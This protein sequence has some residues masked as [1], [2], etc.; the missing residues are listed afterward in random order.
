[1][2]WGCDTWPRSDL[3]RFSELLR[4]TG[5][6]DTARCGICRVLDMLEVSSAG[7][8]IRL[9]AVLANKAC[10]IVG[11]SACRVMGYLIWV[12]TRFAGYRISKMNIDRLDLCVG[13]RCQLLLQEAG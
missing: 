5:V 7:K 8:R 4:G 1:M 11:C 3:E 2:A 6:L 9:A 10:L 13:H 12:R